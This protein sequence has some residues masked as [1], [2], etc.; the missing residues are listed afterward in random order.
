MLS[1]M[2][3]LL[4]TIAFLL[5]ISADAAVLK[6]VTKR[7]RGNYETSSAVPEKKG[8]NARKKD[9]KV[10]QKTYK[11]RSTGIGF[12][13][14]SDWKVEEEGEWF[15]MMPVYDGV[16]EKTKRTSMISAWTEAAAN[17]KDMTVED[18][19][20]FFTNKTTLASENLLV[21]WYVP[22]FKLLSSEDATLFGKPAKKFTYTGEI[23]SV[24]QTF[25]R[26]LTS[27][28][29]KLFTVSYR[30]APETFETDLPVF[31]KFLKSLSLKKPAEKAVKSKG[32]TRK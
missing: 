22:S 13:H 19:E 4:L 1:R 32:R 5:P 7:S 12:S 3:Y 18:I 27:F 21:D 30:S 8:F 17:K 29:Q 11:H 31:E 14:P 24:K 26:Y 28:D 20:K 16:S 9:V 2:K 23:A 15:G 25:V 6:G 10:T